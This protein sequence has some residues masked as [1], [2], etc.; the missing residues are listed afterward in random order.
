ML[1]FI[2]ESSSLR[3]FEAVLSGAYMFKTEIAT[4]YVKIFTIMQWPF[5]LST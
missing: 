1:F 2:I 3:Y 4:W 5:G